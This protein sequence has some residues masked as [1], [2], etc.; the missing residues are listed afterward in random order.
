MVKDGERPFAYKHAKSVLKKS[1]APKPLESLARDYND[2][3][4]NNV[5]VVNDEPNDEEEPLAEGD[6]KLVEED[7]YKKLRHYFR[8]AS[9]AHRAMHDGFP[10]VIKV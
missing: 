1:K 2:D 10:C 5:V 9:S 7:L 8:W 4:D 3:D 6:P